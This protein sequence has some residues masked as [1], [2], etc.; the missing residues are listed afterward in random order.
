MARPV[1]FLKLGGSLITDKARPGVARH[2]VIRRLARELAAIAKRARGARVLLGHGSG[3]YGHPAAAGGG[4]TP[5]ADARRRLDAISRTQRAAAGLHQIVLDALVAAGAR[6]FSFAPSSFLSSSGGRVS[7]RFTE[8]IF[9]ALTRGLLP[10]VYGDVVLDD[11]RGAVVLSTEAIF[12]LLAKEAAG[13]GIR[14]SRAAW[15]GETDGVYDREGV[16]IGRL[17][18]SDALRVARG[19]NGAS[20]IDVTGGMGLRLRTAGTLAKAGVPSI[21]IDGR[22]RGAVTR[23]VSG[24]DGGGTRVSSR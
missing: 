3:S 8:P 11:A 7:G 4:L 21:I 15:L 20:G 1:V 16:K 24:S 10:V 13:H 18:P 23:A 17:T 22:R 6:P 5:G 12:L 2:A 9:A 19:V 14:I